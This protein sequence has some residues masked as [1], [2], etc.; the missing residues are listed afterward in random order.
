[1]NIV[2]LQGHLAQMLERGVS[3]ET[4]VCLPQTYPDETGT[5]SEVLMGIEVEGPLFQLAGNP[6]NIYLPREGRSV[7]LIGYGF[8]DWL[9]KPPFARP[10]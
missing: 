5:V 1:V 6:R 7:V 10:D 4:P 3:P 9:N 2:E 8:H